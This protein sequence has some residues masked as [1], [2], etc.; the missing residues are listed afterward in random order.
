ME[1]RRMGIIS[2]S[3]SH[4]KNQVE[5]Y[6]SQNF[7]DDPG[8]IRSL[9]YACNAFYRSIQRVDPEPLFNPLVNDSPAVKTTPIWKRGVR[10]TFTRKLIHP[11]SREP[12]EPEI[13]TTNDFKHALNNNLQL[14][15][16]VCIDG[17]LDLSGNP[18][19]KQLP[20]YLYVNGNLTLSE[21]EN[22]QALPRKKL[23]VQGDLVVNDCTQLKHITR[24][25][26]VAKD[27]NFT[28]CTRL[29]SLPW[30]VRRLGYRSDSKQRQVHLRNTRVSPLFLFSNKKIKFHHPSYYARAE[31]DREMPTEKEIEKAW[32][33]HA[34][35]QKPFPQLNLAS[36]DRAILYE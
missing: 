10:H 26:K 7:G 15:D 33:R 24:N 35:S 17:D 19:L 22:L 16:S 20:K 36:Q 14:P 34:Q 3:L 5:V 8:L 21:C 13:L 18:S 12:A 30:S 31:S 2:R 6:R 29:N 9:G 25:L 28:G 11:F 4:Y 1:L 32:L 27:L 23:R